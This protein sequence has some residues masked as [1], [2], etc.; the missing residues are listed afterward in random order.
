MNFFKKL[1]IF[2]RDS[3]DRKYLDNLISKLPDS[4]L[5]A[6]DILSELNNSKTKCIIDKDIKGSYYVYLNDT[7]Y[8]CDKQSEKENY[9]R[10]CVISHESVHS[11][12]PKFLQNINFILSNLEIIAFVIF[13][14]L[15]FLKVERLYIYLGYLVVAIISM[16]PRIIL[17]FWAMIKAPKVA[18]KYLEKQKVKSEDINKIY[19]YYKFSTMVLMPVAVIGF[20]TYKIIRIIIATILFKIYI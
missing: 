16:I 3:S 11:V 2:K 18:K 9:E 5:L 6:K 13:L 19:D 15:Y 1:K 7:M 14:I 20:F 12:Q 17:E 10:L 4:S 8:L